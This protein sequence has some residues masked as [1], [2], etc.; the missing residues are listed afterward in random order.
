MTEI[1]NELMYEVLKAI[2][3]DVAAMKTDLANL[4]AAQLR[5]R[6]AFHRFR[7]I[8][9]VS[10]G[11]KRRH[12]F[13]STGSKPVSDC[14]TAPL[15][16][17]DTVSPIFPVFSNFRQWIL[18]GPQKDSDPSL[19]VPQSHGSHCSNRRKVKNALADVA[20]VDR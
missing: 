5:M 8:C 3:A 19:P 7:A 4:K 6:E 2:R 16:R 12:S 1:T 11:C 13:I 9:C 17:P 20:I 15:F 14:R 10:N 18:I